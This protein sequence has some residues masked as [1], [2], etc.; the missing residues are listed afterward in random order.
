MKRVCLFKILLLFGFITFS[1]VGVLQSAKA[2]E[3]IEK[4]FLSLNSVEYP[5]S[6][7]GFQKVSPILRTLIEKV[8]TGAITKQYARGQGDV[9]L[10]DSLV[11][12]NEVGNIQTYIH[13]DSIGSEERARIEAYDVK[14]EIT[15][16]KLG[17]IQAW[18]PYNKIDE[19][20][21]FPFVKRITAPRYGA[22]RGG[23]VNMETDAIFS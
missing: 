20:A 18:I 11:R 5:K 1:P 12:V 8:R 10:S 9:V 16:E 3:G 14:V 17:I 7:L 22:P 19:V 15:N 23:S 6:S 21:Q 4:P 13:V 2:G